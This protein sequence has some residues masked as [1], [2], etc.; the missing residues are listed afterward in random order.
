MAA[1]AV[2]SCYPMLGMKLFVTLTTRFGLFHPDH[3]FFE[4]TMLTQV[5][6]PCP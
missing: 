3:P 1:A 2:S 6:E 5:A 4:A